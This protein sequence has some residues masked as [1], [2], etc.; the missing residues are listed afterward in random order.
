MPTSF[1]FLVIPVRQ[2]RPPASS[3]EAAHRPN[4]LPDFF[5]LISSGRI[6]AL[7]DLE[8]TLILGDDDSM[9]CS[10]TSVRRD[11]RKHCRMNSRVGRPHLIIILNEAEASGDGLSGRTALRTPPLREGRFG[12]GRRRRLRIRSPLKERSEVTIENTCDFHTL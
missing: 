1:D 12:R 11:H 2:N 5:L 4:T 7:S 10:F 6:S 3:E 9:A 8:G